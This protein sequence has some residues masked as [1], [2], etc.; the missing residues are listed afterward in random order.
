MNTCLQVHE[1]TAVGR[2]SRHNMNCSSLVTRLASSAN[3][4]DRLTYQRIIVFNL[5][6][7]RLCSQRVFDGLEIVKLL[8]GWSA[9]KAQATLGHFTE[10]RI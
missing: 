7:G 4:C 2:S 1:P 6:H 9:E 3:N 10:V 8:G 5:L